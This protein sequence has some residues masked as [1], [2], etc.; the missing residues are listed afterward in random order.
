MG[1]T[2]VATPEERFVVASAGP[3][4]LG[5]RSAPGGVRKIGI[6]LTIQRD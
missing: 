2:E 3:E 6:W 4:N 1:V 5:L